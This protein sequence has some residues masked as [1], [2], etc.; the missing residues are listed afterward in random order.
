MSIRSSNK[1]F[2]K[3]C[4]AFCDHPLHENPFPVVGV[5]LTNSS[6]EKSVQT[7]ASIDGV[8]GRNILLLVLLSCCCCAFLAYKCC[9]SAFDGF[10]PQDGNKHHQGY[11]D[12]YNQ[13][14]PM[15][16]YPQQ[17]YPQHQ[18]YPPNQGY[19]PQGGYHPQQGYPQSYPAHPTY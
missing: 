5:L 13:Q 10:L 19:P 1:Q 11:A 16:Q 6:N 15:Q 3:C 12:D 4:W 14:Y 18:G 8:I 7:C 9:R 2:C 17:S